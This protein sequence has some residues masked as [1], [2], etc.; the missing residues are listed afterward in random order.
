MTLFGS[1]YNRFLGKI[2]DDM[3]MELTPSDTIKDLQNLLIEA[4][5]G[6]EFPRKDLYDYKIK[7]VEIGE[8]ELVPDDFILGTVWGEI[9]DINSL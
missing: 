9:P 6:F 7:V 3:Y 2:T 8:D 1:V 5:P 4:I